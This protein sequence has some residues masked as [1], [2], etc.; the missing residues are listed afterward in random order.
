[1]ELFSMACK[2]VRELRDDT[3]SKLIEFNR[4]LKIGYSSIQT[5]QTQMAK[6]MP[7]RT[8]EMAQSLRQIELNLQALDTK[9]EYHAQDSLV[10]IRNIQ[11]PVPDFQTM[12]STPALQMPD[13]F[14][15]PK[16]D[17]F[18]AIE[19]FKARPDLKL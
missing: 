15:L 1:M 18:P 13:D 14:R 17:L 4:E 7:Q 2:E 3:L 19:P 12:L 8:K 16:Q 10:Q 9:A 11:N 6:E 5:K